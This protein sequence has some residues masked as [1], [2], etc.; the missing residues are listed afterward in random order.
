MSRARKPDPR[1]LYDA[2]PLACMSDAELAAFHAETGMHRADDAGDLAARCAESAFF[3]RRDVSLLDALCTLEQRLRQLDALLRLMAVASGTAADS[4]EAAAACGV[5]CAEA[6]GL[7]GLALRAVSVAV[8]A[9][10]PC[11]GGD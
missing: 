6:L 2:T 3:V 5:L 1:T 10:A 8:D 4:Q 9:G 7:Q 11:P